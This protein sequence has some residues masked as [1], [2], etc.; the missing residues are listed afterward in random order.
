MEAAIDEGDEAPVAGRAVRMKRSP[1]GRHRVVKVS[2]TEEEHAGL[3]FRAAASGVSLQR[4]L[5]EAGMSGSVSDGAARRAERELTQ[6]R[7][8]L[9]A[10]GN[11]L[12]QLAKWANANRTLPTHMESILATVEQAAKTVEVRA[13]RLADTFGEP[14]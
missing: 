9:R 2:L 4:Y 5:I 6:A 10:A 12:N 3:A 7:G 13:G 14:S 8:V 11:N 1:G